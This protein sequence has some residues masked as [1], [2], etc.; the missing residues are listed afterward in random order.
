APSTTSSWQVE[1][2]WLLV[3]ARASPVASTSERGPVPA[4]L[5]PSS[6]IRHGPSTTRLNDVQRGGWDAGRVEPVQHP[7]APLCTSPATASPDSRAAQIRR[8]A[9]SYQ[10]LLVPFAVLTALAGHVVSPYI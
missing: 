10:E 2:S 1:V 6:R 7:N 5:H 8:V 3:P 9:R 4:S